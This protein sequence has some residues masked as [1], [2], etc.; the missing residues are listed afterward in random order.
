MEKPSGILKP[1]RSSIVNSSK[2]G[3]SGM[4]DM[5]I[6][7]DA[8]KVLINVPVGMEVELIGQQ[9]SSM[10]DENHPVSFMEE[11]SSSDEFARKRKQKQKEDYARVRESLRMR[12]EP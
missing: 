7:K 10:V 8:H 11:H 4:G 9:S 5:E 3:F 6:E 2:G 12:F 1:C